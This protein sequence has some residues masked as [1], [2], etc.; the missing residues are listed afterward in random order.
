LIKELVSESMEA[1]R[2]SV[3]WNGTDRANRRVASGV[4]FY[5]I[6]AGPLNDTQRMLL[7]K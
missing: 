4:Y 7:V 6:Q 5:Q 1:G 3:V 2:H